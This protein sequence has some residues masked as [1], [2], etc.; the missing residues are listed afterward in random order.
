V[1]WV[2]TRALLR[3]LI[4]KMAVFMNPFIVLLLA[5]LFPRVVRDLPLDRLPV[6][7][8]VV[9]AAFGAVFTFI[10]L[11]R[12]L[13]NQFAVHGAGFTLQA[14][15]PLSERDLVWGKMVGCA[16]LGAMAY[17]IFLVFLVP[18]SGG[19]HPAPLLACVL[20]AASAYL[21]F[22]PLAAVLA[23]IFPKA[24]DLT[25]MG[26]ASNPHAI[27]NVV[28]FL[29][30]NALCAPPVALYFYGAVLRKSPALGCGLVAGWAA[31]TCALSVPL[32]RLA[33][34]TLAGRRE[35]VA[36]VAQGR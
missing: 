27:A 25:R 2:E 26:S 29:T 3:T 18:M 16:I 11:E 32:V 6:D 28:G 23:A 17:G 1:A 9:F 8:G 7:R 22:A 34:A 13:L 19:I 10:S 5:F 21:L 24:A 30:G 20:G 4:G 31:V 33:A 14:L 35:N 15:A 12:I 36:M